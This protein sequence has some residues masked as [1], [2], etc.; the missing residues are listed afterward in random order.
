MTAANPRITAPLQPLAL[1]LITK[2]LKR[3]LFVFAL[4]HRIHTVAV[5]ARFTV[6]KENI[7]GM[8]FLLNTGDIFFKNPAVKNHR[9]VRIFDEN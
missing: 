7:F 2:S 4:H 6:K 9:I 5:S 8:I 3:Q 1:Q